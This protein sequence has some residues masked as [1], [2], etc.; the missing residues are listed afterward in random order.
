MDGFMAVT[1][2]MLLE[3]KG[4]ELAHSGTALG[5]IFT[6]AMLGGVVSPP[7]GNSLAGINA[8]LPFVFWAS[9]SAVAALTLSFVED[10]GR[11]SKTA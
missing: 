4:V 8:G 3:T 10:T 1:I 6:I 2:T 5:M 7:L 11:R 9:L